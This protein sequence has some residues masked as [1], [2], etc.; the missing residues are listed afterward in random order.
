MKFIAENRNL[1]TCVADSIAGAVT[2]V[3]QAGEL[4][5][6][7]TG[8]PSEPEKEQFHPYGIATNTDI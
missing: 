4:R 7:Y 1:D 8:H 6:C 5:L 2:V 3:N